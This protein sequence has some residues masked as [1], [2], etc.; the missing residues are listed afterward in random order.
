MISFNVRAAC[1]PKNTSKDVSFQPPASNFERQR[2]QV[3]YLRDY[4]NGDKKEKH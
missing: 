3:L 2:Q 1:K 4:F